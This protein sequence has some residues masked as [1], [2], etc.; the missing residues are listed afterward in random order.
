MTDRLTLAN[1]CSTDAIVPV[2]CS[3]GITRGLSSGFLNTAILGGG[4]ARGGKGGGGGGGAIVGAI[5]GAMCT[6]TAGL[7]TTKGLD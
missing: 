5:V 2:D 1:S 3:C 4:G 7:G 6:F